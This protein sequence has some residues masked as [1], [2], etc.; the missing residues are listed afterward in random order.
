MN[1]VADILR[2]LVRSAVQPKPIEK[3]WAWLDRNVSVP[4]I[5]G[6]KFPGPLDTKLM[7]PFR[8]LYEKY[9]DSRT[10]FFTFVKS[11]RVGGTLF[12]ICLMLEKIGRW[13][14]PI[15]YV[16]PTLKNVMRFSLNELQPHMLECPPVAAV[17]IPTKTHWTRT[18][19]V[20]KVC[21][22]G[23]VSAGS[24]NQ[25]ASRQAELLIIDEADKIKVKL[26]VEAPPTELA[27]VRTKQFTDTRKV[28]RTG[29]QRSAAARYG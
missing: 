19:M 5:T 11:A 22:V 4:L 18:E 16:G 8:G 6:T 10:R 3:F 20:L 15:L 28:V 23:L 29:R 24:V 2:S 26:G 13:P 7:P 14:G 1:R 17:R 27:I 25:L 12:C 9:G 21:S